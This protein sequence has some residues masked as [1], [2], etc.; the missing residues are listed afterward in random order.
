M[1]RLILLFLVC[2]C[3]I[4]VF[5]SPLARKYTTF[6]TEKGLLY[7]IRP[8][9]MPKCD[10]N[11]TKYG[12]T[13]DITYL[14]GDND[15]VSFTATVVTPTVEKLDYVYIKNES[16]R[17]KA[18]PELIYC[19]PYKSYYVN[20]IR[21]YIKW[22]EWKEIYSCMTPYTIVFGDHLCFSFSQGRWRKE[23]KIINNIMN[24]IE[25]NK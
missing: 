16:T 23:S 2:T 14:Y 3:S 4:V 17:I 24:I 11:L 5:A 18:I 13:F 9:H 19:E 15:S 1:K 12:L 6:L 10:G 25:I 7:F 20:R 8:M 22:A 21:F